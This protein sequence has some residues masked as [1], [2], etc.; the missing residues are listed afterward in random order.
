MERKT[1][2]LEQKP[3]LL[4]NLPPPPTDETFTALGFQK[5][6]K[7]EVKDGNHA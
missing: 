5:T 2:N 6:P 4:D 7:Q 3:L 1:E